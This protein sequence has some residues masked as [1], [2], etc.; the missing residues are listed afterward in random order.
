[1]NQTDNKK[2]H[3][4]IDGVLLTGT[5][6][7]KISLTDHFIEKR[8][9]ERL[10]MMVMKGN[11]DQNFGLLQ[12]A[13]NSLFHLPIVV[14]IGDGVELT[15]SVLDAENKVKHFNATNVQ[16]LY[17]KFENAK[18]FMKLHNQPLKV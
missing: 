12:R 1:M 14:N 5:Q 4:N 15:I 6:E 8:G 9:F 13:L 7:A 18:H 11:I 16:G 3:L 2:L 17:Q 10:A